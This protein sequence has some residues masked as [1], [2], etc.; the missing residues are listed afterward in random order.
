MMVLSQKL[1]D[2]EKSRSVPMYMFVVSWL[3]EYEDLEPNEKLC[4]SKMEV[5]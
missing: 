1:T 5:L 4:W 2:Y 3:Y